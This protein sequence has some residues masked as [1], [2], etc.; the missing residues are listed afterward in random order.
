MSI[1][2]LKSKFDTIYI[3][4]ITILIAMGISALLNNLL[5][6]L[7][8]GFCGNILL[9]NHLIFSLKNTCI[10]Q[11]IPKTPKKTK[12]IKKVIEVL[13]DEDGNEIV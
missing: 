3:L 5:V 9:V 7:F 2:H 1:Q 4:S 11:Q 12:K 8:V 13:V 6:L 10:N